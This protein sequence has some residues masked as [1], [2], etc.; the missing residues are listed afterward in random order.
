MEKKNITGQGDK[1]GRA[2][3]ATTARFLEKERQGV[4]FI[5]GHEFDETKKKG[6]NIRETNRLKKTKEI[7][8]DK[9]GMAEERAGH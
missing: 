9:A 8:G 3:G 7:L 6:G 2:L 5:K 4:L 1:M